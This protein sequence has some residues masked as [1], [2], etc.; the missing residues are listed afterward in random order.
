MIDFILEDQIIHVELDAY[1]DALVRTW[2]D[3]DL[4]LGV[5]KALTCIHEH[6]YEE[7]LNVAF[8]RE[9]CKLRNNNVSS[10]FK[11]IVGVGM[12]VYIER[13]RIGTARRLLG[14]D[15]LRVLAVARAVGYADVETFER[16]FKRCEQ[17]CPSRFRS[18]LASGERTLETGYKDRSSR[19][20]VKTGSKE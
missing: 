7:Q 12:R 3:V 6:L 14:N 4:P 9:T 18:L 11:W 2:Q 10:R 5:A 17:C 8:V 13:H 20:E 15:E 1:R 19:M 16:A